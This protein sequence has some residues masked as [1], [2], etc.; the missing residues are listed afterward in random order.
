V[1]TGFFSSMAPVNRAISNPA[2]SAA[3]VS[4]A[5]ISTQAIERRPGR[6]RCVFVVIPFSFYFFVSVQVWM[7]IIAILTTVAPRPKK[8]TAFGFDFILFYFILFYFILFYTMIH[9]FPCPLE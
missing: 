5:P 4:V 1:L 7:Y 6:E 3:P 2:E 8:M 9:V